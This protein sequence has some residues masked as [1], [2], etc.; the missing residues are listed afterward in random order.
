MPMNH[1]QLM[2]ALRTAHVRTAESVVIRNLQ[3]KG[4]VATTESQCAHFWSEPDEFD[5]VECCWCGQTR[6][7][8]L[9]HDDDANNSLQRTPAAGG[10]LGGIGST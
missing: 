2:D 4:L 9:K 3:R 5:R 7:A 1:E 6:S 8:D 10:T